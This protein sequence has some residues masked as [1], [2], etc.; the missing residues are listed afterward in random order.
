MYC[1]YHNAFKSTP[2]QIMYYYTIKYYSFCFNDRFS[3]LYFI[4]RHESIFLLIKWKWTVF[5]Q[6]DIKC[7]F[8]DRIKE[9]IESR[10][11]NFHNNELLQNL[12]RTISSFST[13]MPDKNRYR[14]NVLLNTNSISTYK[15][16]FRYTKKW[17]II[18]M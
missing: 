7:I 16:K 15:T 18:Y 12:I 13:I 11:V 14:L 8:K 5:L 1:F 4:R 10:A 9:F 6:I 3:V 17:N 2:I